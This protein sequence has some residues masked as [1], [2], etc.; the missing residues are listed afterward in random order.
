MNF[1]NSPEAVNR[2]RLL[3]QLQRKL[4]GIPRDH[5]PL[6]TLDEVVSQAPKALSL[7]NI[8]QDLQLSVFLGMRTLIDVSS[9]YAVQDER[10]QKLDLTRAI[11][12][13]RLDPAHQFQRYHDANRW[14]IA[15]FL[16]L[17]TAPKTSP[18]KYGPRN[19]AV[20]FP[21]SARR[22]VIS[23]LAAVLEHHNTP[24]EFQ[25]R[26]RFI[27]LWKGSRYDFFTFRAGNAKVLKSLMKVFSKQWDDELER[28][29]TKVGLEMFEKRVAKFVGVLVP[30]RRE[31]RLQVMSEVCIIPKVGS[32][33][34]SP[35]RRILYPEHGCLLRQLNSN[36]NLQ[37]AQPEAPAMPAG[38]LL[39]ALKTSIKPQKPV[40][41]SEP[42][43]QADSVAHVR[44][45]LSLLKESH[46]RVLL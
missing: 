28:V 37:I 5:L 43:T 19:D 39:A 2:D 36:S 46:P 12:Y 15:L 9:G 11:F 42:N 14:N 38:T 35:F 32:Q 27:K 7:P 17:L 22:W 24:T 8:P 20:W 40:K 21:D 34:V 31:H 30:G 10:R 23:Y 45:A 6:L 13:Y 33:A 41:Q 25:A 18:E 16:A 3:K 26:E 1:L 44:V 29:K 4:S